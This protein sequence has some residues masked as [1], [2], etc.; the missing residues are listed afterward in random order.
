M[1]RGSR[2]RPTPIDRNAARPTDRPPA[3]AGRSGP[4]ARLRARW[5]PGPWRPDATALTV[6]TLLLLLIGLVMSFSA[7]FV[8][9]AVAGDPFATFRRQAQWAVIGVVAFVVAANLDHRIWRSLSWVL[10]V[11]SVIGLVLVLVPG[12]GVER[13]GSTR[14]IGVPPLVFQPSELAKLAALLWLADVFERKRPRD[15]SPHQTDHLLVPALPLLVLLALLVMMQPDLGTTI[16]LGLIVGAVL[17]VEGLPGRYVAAAVVAAA[18]A[19]AV[20]AAV[21]PYRVARIRG[22]LWPERFPLDEGFQLLQSRYALGSGG[23]FGVGLGS[24]RGKWNFIPNPET[25]FIFAIIGEEL[26][27]VGAVGVVLLFG[28]LLFLG[29]KTAYGAVDGFGRTVALAVTAWLVGQA[30][31]NIG[32]V[33]GLL[34]ITGVTLPLVSVGGSSL[35]STLLALGILVAIARREPEPSRLSTTRTTRG[36]SLT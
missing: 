9:G 29:L 12:V 6:V 25:D 10:L 30:L 36:R 21:A 28:A 20:L 1:T 16:L 4:L 22:W 3:S 13:Y 35:V 17:W 18:S 32:T 33:I 15:G 2:G 24:S 5:Q 23:L 31:V 27:L 26:G 14:W 34:P 11:A 19:V 8:D 7:S